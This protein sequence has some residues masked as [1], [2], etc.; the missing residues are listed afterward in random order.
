MSM[1]ESPKRMSH[2]GSP[3]SSPLLSTPTR[4]RPIDINN[5]AGSSPSSPV[6][7]KGSH[8]GKGYFPS[9]G[10]DDLRSIISSPSLTSDQLKSISK[11]PLA[12]RMHI[13]SSNPSKDKYVIPIPL[14]L[15]LPPK[16]SLPQKSPKSQSFTP[17]SPSPNSTPRKPKRQT[18][19]YT[20]HGYEKIE[21]S[22]SSED[23]SEES[24]LLPV[25]G[26]TSL[27]K[28]TQ[29]PSVATNKTKYSKLAFQNKDPDELSMIE[30]VSNFGSRNSSVARG[31]N[32]GLQHEVSKKLPSLPTELEEF[33]P[34]GSDSSAILH[35]KYHTGH[36]G[37]PEAIEME[38]KQPRRTP[39]P[40]KEICSIAS[41]A[42]N[43]QVPMPQEY[44]TKLAHSRCFSETS[45]VSSV[46]SFSSAGAFGLMNSGHRTGPN[47]RTAAPTRNE[48]P[49]GSANVA[50]ITSLNKPNAITERQV[51]DT[52]QL[53]TGSSSSW[54]SLQQSIDISLNREVS[55]S[56]NHSS[57]ERK[58]SK[59]TDDENLWTDESATDSEGFGE[60][61]SPLNI[62]RQNT[63]A[64]SASI[65]SPVNK[66]AHN[67]CDTDFEHKGSGIAFNFPNNSNNITNNKILKS[68]QLDEDAKSAKSR[69]SFYSNGQ[70]EIPD[71]T[72]GKVMDQFSSKTPS[73]YDEAVFSERHTETSVS[74]FERDDQDSRKIRVP[75]RDALNHFQE[76]FKLYSADDD[77]DN[78]ATLKS[79]ALYAAPT[80][81][82]T[83]PD[84]QC[85]F[86]Q[87]RQIST[88]PVRHRRGKSMYNI[89]F[90]SNDGPQETHHQSHQKSKSIDCNSTCKSHLVTN[91][92][93]STAVGVTKK[94]TFEKRHSSKIQDAVPEDLNIRV[95]EPPKAVNYAIDFKVNNTTDNDFGN[96]FTT[97]KAIDKRHGLKPRHG[98]PKKAS[99]SDISSRKDESD[100]ESVVIDLTDDTYNVVTIK[101]SDSTISYRSVTEKHRGKNVEV[102]LLDDEEDARDETN[103]SKNEE[104]DETDDELSS[105]YSKYR[106][107]SWL[108]GPKSSNSSEASFEAKSSYSN[109]NV[110]SRSPRKSE[111]LQGLRSLT[112]AGRILHELNLKRSNTTTSSNTS[113]SSKSNDRKVSS[114]APSRMSMNRAS[115][116][117]LDDKYFDYA[118][119]GN[120]NFQTFMNERK[121]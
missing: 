16:L 85:N 62:T 111:N 3:A 107:D 66:Q 42:N 82:K 71:L 89:D 11:S 80:I 52:S 27:A 30:E 112:T 23:E 96:K 28:K 74:D 31:T 15:R 51:S 44:N 29:P 77:S 105:I 50:L 83:A 1:P 68:K 25:P 7:D 119:N 121:F 91:S 93:G 73:S 55:E 17:P 116:S 86:T 13:V 102:I 120:Y 53:S 58:S 47:A 78:E 45:Q 12:R 6:K 24:V 84:L 69:Y 39:L 9:M 2:R 109:I 88:S 48:K 36:K 38:E 21:V 79:S 37:K 14:T 34:T 98:S 20:S 101:R 113:P 10:E 67:D 26:K 22:S 75:S 95:A 72:N 117:Y 110:K 118:M 76:Q 65:R 70:I 103:E 43:V 18:L 54:N 92:H 61:I 57:E 32:Q 40:P 41:A 8:C 100:T 115:T 64:T 49:D 108:F 114:A 5:S 104:G 87:P 19:I 106:N 81:S 59:Q 94:N 4:A 99:R 97:P 60:E 63:G 33:A 56:E 35:N 90:N 46:S